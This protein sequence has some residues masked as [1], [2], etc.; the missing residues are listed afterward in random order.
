MMLSMKYIETL[1][2]SAIMLFHFT[3]SLRVS[4]QTQSADITYSIASNFTLG[5][6]P[7]YAKGWL[8]Y[9]NFPIQ[10]RNKPK[11]FFKNMAFY[12]QFKNGKTVDLT[13][14]D[15]VYYILI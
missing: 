10:D 3:Y 2:I 12:E 1:L 6:G 4:T 14:I 7:I 11:E 5:E 15:K 8:K 9:T 13:K